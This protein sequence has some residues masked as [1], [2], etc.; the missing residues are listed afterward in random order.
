MM[1]NPQGSIVLKALIQALS[2]QTSLI[3]YSFHWLDSNIRGDVVFLLEVPIQASLDP[4]G[5]H[6][7]HGGTE[8][9]V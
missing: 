9:I 8:S 5:G 1:F 3:F 6:F 2:L 4:A 7:S